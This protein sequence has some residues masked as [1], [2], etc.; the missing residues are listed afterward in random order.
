[1]NNSSGAVVRTDLN[2]YVEEASG[3]DE[4]LI[5]EKVFPAYEV[6]VKDGT[7]PKFSLAGGSELLDVDVSIR[8]PRGS[9]KRV[10][11]T[12]TM[13]TYSTVDRGLEELVDDEEKR[14]N[15][16]FFDQE[17]AAAKFVLRR[18]KLALEVR[19]AA[20]LFDSGVFN[21]TDAIVDYLATN[22][23]TLDPVGDITGATDRLAG[24]GV[25]PNTMVLS[26]FVFTLMR[27]SKIMQDYIRGN[28]PSDSTIN[29]SPQMIADA[30][31][32]Q[33]CLVAKAPKNVAA[34]GKASSLAPIW[35]TDFIWIGNVQGGD[36]HNG[37]AGRT[38]VWNAEGGL[39]VT[40][41]Y[42]AE[43]NRSDVVRVRQ[44]TTEKVIDPTVGELINTGYVA[45]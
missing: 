38:L 33:Q 22:L 19:V 42:R 25:V 34:K 4:T 20:K 11:R 16:R 7:Y 14:D 23:A 35:S 28:R 31:D 32:L 5:A 24:R 43:T 2:T 40:E 8:A 45:A 39:F 26:H 30:F 29:I 37:G 9:Y 1:M 41:S 27:R 12:Y 21:D 15:A 36:P 18:M 17:V 10:Q 44:H 3:V 13:D 6:G